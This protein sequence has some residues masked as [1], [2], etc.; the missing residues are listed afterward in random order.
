MR[1]R[2]D[3]IA[4]GADLLREGGPDALTTV[5]VAERLG[6]TQ[7]AIYRHVDSVDELL[8]L[9]AERVADD[10]RSLL[11]TV[12]PPKPS[13]IA[14]RDEMIGIADGLVAAMVDDA[15]AFE[16]VD[17]WRYDDGPLGE[18]IRTYLEESFDLLAV[19]VEERWRRNASYTG[20]L[21]RPLQRVLR[22]HAR[23]LHSDL[24]D[25]AAIVRRGRYPGGRAAIAELLA[26][27]LRIHAI[28]VTVDLNHRL[29]LPPP[30][31]DNNPILTFPTGR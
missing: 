10:L 20:P 4:A 3:V 24:T 22:E 27:R 7:S 17:R 18:G 13:A 19:I 8:K 2:D 30:L 21:T 11:T 1:T 9:S 26:I 16:I 5:A 12:R 25:V 31:L 23:F 29:G 28:A 14:P 6:I 15:H